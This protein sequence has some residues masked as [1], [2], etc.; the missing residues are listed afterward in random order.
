[1]AY[2]IRHHEGQT[3]TASGLDVLAGIWLLIS[4]FVLAF[5]HI[6][7]AA[8]NNVI[9]GIVIGLLALYRFMNPATNAGVSWLNV[10]LGIWVLISP[11]VIGFSTYHV[12]T[13]NNVIMGI[14]VIILAGWSAL[15]TGSGSNTSG[16]N[17]TL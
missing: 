7:A 9:F 5:Q 4:P 1:M 12:P 3:V 8:T 2:A 13:T 14:V 16:M 10:I 17:P 15:A 11:F 6:N